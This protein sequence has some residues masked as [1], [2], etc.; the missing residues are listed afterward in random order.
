MWQHN[1][2]VERERVL[3]P[4]KLERI[5]GVGPL[6]FDLLLFSYL[7][8]YTTRG[9][10]YIKPT[11]EPCYPLTR[12]KERFSRAKD[13]KNA[14]ELITTRDLFGRLAFCVLYLESFLGPLA[15]YQPIYDV[16]VHAI[17]TKQI[18]DEDKSSELALLE[19]L[20]SKRATLHH[21]L[22]KME[23]ECDFTGI[24]SHVKKAIDE[25]HPL[26]K[27]LSSFTVK[28]ALRNYW[29][30]LDIVK[31]KCVSY[32]QYRE[33]V[34]DI[35]YGLFKLGYSKVD[36][37][38]GVSFLHDHTTLKDHASPMS[39]RQFAAITQSGSNLNA[40]LL[41]MIVLPLANSAWPEKL[42]G[43]EA[44]KPAVKSYAN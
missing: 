42:S 34:F 16:L 1:P 8:S 5:I 33:R 31:A 11:G 23:L 43:D 29:Q 12:L 22:K 18:P 10:G 13:L 3:L 14:G 32:Y 28:I 4:K 36:K 19:L 27:E 9:T 40:I 30:N 15:C 35:G 41:K 44:K 26:F 17:E 39:Q 24:I 20:T 25:E 21:F 7:L 37:I 38:N 6:A 2:K